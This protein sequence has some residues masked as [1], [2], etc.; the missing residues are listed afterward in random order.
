MKRT[1]LLKY[2]KSYGCVLYR[3]GGNHSVYWNPDNLKT[4]T[5]PRHREIDDKLALK[6]CKDL[7]IPVPKHRN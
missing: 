1:V 2:L 7:G 4:T 6:I 3:E 5:I